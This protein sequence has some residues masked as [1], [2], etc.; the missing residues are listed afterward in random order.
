L[1]YR[2]LDKFRS[3]FEGKRYIHRASNLGDLIA[4]ELYED[5]C[6]LAKSTLLRNRIAQAERV[7]NVKNRRV[8]IRARRGICGGSRANCNR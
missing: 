8:G 1:P 2:L 5:L 4:M 6:Y 7:L 3:T